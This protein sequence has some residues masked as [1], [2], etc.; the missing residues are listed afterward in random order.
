MFFSLHE[1]VYIWQFLL[2][3]LSIATACTVPISAINCTGA[4]LSGCLYLPVYETLC[5]VTAH[6]AGQYYLFQSSICISVH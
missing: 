3:F 5:H 2:K 1:Y 4:G 6:S